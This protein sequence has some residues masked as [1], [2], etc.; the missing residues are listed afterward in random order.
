MKK[1]V[2]ML[3]FV[4]LVIF[5]CACGNTYKI[6]VVGAA[7]LVVS[8]PKSA[9]TGE[10]VTVETKDVSDGQV[11]VTAS[12]PDV[13]AV[14]GDLFQFVMPKQNVDVRILFVGDELS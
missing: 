11:E 2:F 6:K 5:L 12:G 9:K 3:L 1:P 10:T 7:D 13:E 8:C 4:A 14:R